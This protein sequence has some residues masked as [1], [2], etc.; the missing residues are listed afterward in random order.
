MGAVFAITVPLFL[1]LALGYLAQRTGLFPEAA[2]KGLG[3]F[4][5][6]FALPALLFRTMLAAPLAEVFAADVVLAYMAAGAAAF[7][8][9][10]GVAAWSLRLALGEAA[11]QGMAASFGNVVLIALPIISASF[12]PA[13]TQQLALLLVFENAMLIP[14]TMLLLEMARRRTGPAWLLALW[15][16]GRIAGSPV[17]LAVAA[18]AAANLA[19]LGLP[20]PIDG[21]ARLLAAAAVP[22]ALFALGVTLAGKPLGERLP[23]VGFMTATKLF[24]H[25][26]LVYVATAFLPGLDPSMRAAAVLAASMP[27][28]VN[29]Y[30]LATQYGSGARTASAAVLLSHVAAL[31]TI[32]LTLFALLSGHAPGP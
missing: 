8:A 25:P 20:G 9:G 19:G 31:P 28:G 5:F 4:V 13:A 21:A 7:L 12:G 18:G 22:G 17:I 15:L 2:L 3:N 1:V 32:S 27:V 14:V 11:I 16:A 23:E 26:A 6:Y 24:L 10:A 29:V 30:L